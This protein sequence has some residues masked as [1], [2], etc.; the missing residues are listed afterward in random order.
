MEDGVHSL[1]GRN[2]RLLVEVESKYLPGLVLLLLLKRVEL[3]VR[4]LILEISPVQF[5]VIQ[6]IAPSASA[7]KF[8]TSYTDKEIR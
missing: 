4:D 7:I 2:A 8:L 3:I 1:P 6:V 5:S